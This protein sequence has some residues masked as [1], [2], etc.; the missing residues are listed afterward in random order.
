MGKKKEMVADCIRE[1]RCMMGED[2]PVFLCG[3]PSSIKEVAKMQVCE[4][5]SYTYMADMVRDDDG[6][7][8]SVCYDKVLTD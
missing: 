2:I 4:K 6:N 8:L 1:L 5:G 3:K 7:L